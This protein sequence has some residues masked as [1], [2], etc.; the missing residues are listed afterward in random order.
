MKKEAKRSEGGLEADAKK[1]VNV[2]MALEGKV[3]TIVVDLGRKGEVSASGKSVV[4]AS[5][6]G[7]VEVVDGVFVGLNVYRPR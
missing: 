5:T 3:L 1:M 4:I 2:D 7:N 6:K